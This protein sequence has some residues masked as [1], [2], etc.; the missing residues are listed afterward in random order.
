MLSRKQ[1]NVLAAIGNS[2][3]DLEVDGKRLSTCSRE[4]A[5]I[6]ESLDQI[7]EFTSGAVALT[8]TLNEA[9]IIAKEV[10]TIQRHL[11]TMLDNVFDLTQVED[12][13][14]MSKS[15][16]KRLEIQKR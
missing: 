7:Q 14:V 3:R 11:S 16:L 8:R 1:M 15:V 13:P 2:V 5:K 9:R 10:S 12:E 6:L 4:A